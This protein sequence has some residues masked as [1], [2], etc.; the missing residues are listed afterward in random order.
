[1]HEKKKKKRELRENYTHTHTGEKNGSQKLKAV[2]KCGYAAF[3][4]WAVLAD[5][6]APRSTLS[7]WHAVAL[8]DSIFNPLGTGS[9]KPEVERMLVVRRQSEHFTAVWDTQE[10]PKELCV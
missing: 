5:N 8:E 10:S 9:A 6:P 7:R 1:M 3:I 2:F 4:C